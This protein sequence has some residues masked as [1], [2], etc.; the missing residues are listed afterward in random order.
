M[1]QNSKIL[2]VDDD[3]DLRNFI[4]LSLDN[5]KRHI[6]EAGTALD[7]LHCANELPPDIL[8]LDIGLPGH[9]NGFALCESL[10]TDPRHHK[11]RVVVI[12]GQG[13]EEDIDQAKRLG[14]VAYIVKPVSPTT[15]VEL[16]EKLEAQVQEMM[17][18][19]P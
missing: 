17:T 2:I 12:S 5:G 19:V 8:L 18:I 9:F 10:C 4:R 13:E 3:A 14:V 16:V 15:L 1:T 6:T 7:G 11:L